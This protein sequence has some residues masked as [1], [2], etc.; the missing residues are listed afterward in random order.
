MPG[1]P[2]PRRPPVAHQR[3]Q[4]P[5]RLRASAQARFGG[6]CADLRC[7]AAELR[8]SAL[9]GANTKQTSAEGCGETS[10]GLQRN[11]CSRSVIGV[12]QSAR[13]VTNRVLA[14]VR[15]LREECLHIRWASLW[16]PGSTSWGSRLR[17]LCSRRGGAPEPRLRA[18]AQAPPKCSN[19]KSTS[20]SRQH[21]RVNG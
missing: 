5:W 15:S 19:T 1:P 18:G 10:N 7:E 9:T 16:N 4:A 8:R 13:S 21:L 17:G 20:L 3:C 14:H 6:S 12:R 2:G 11:T